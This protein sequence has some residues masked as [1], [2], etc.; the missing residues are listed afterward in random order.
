MERRMFLGTLTTTSI[1]AV[2]DG[3]FPNLALSNIDVQTD[4][5]ATGQVNFEGFSSQSCGEFCFNTPL[6]VIE[7]VARP[8]RVELPTFWFVARRSIQLSYGR[9]GFIVAQ[10]ESRRDGG[11]TVRR[12]GNGGRG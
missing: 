10:G 4:P 2:L 3:S 7:K 12:G 8:E 9:V 6:R 1:G 5:I 11:D